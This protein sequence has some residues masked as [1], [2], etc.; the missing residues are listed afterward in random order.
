MKRTLLEKLADPVQR[1]P[2]SLEGATEGAPAVDAGVLRG[3]DGAAYPITA[4]IPRFVLTSDAGQA[5]T[6]KA[7]GFKWKK[8]DTYDSPAA[9]AVAA[10]WYLEK[11]DFASLDEW[12]A[13]FDRRESVIDIGSGSGFSSSLFLESPRWTGHAAWIGVDISEAIDVAKERLSSI[14]NTHFVQG[15]ALQLPFRDGG[16][17]TV[18]SE[19][20]MHHT[21]STHDALLSAARVLATGGEACFYVYKKKAP[22]REYTDD[23]VRAQ[24]APLSDD[25]AWDAMRSLTELGRALSATRATVDLKVDVPLLGIK[26]GAQDV[27]RLIYWNV[28]K[29]YWNDAL[30]FEEN[31]HI[32]FDWYRPRYAHRQTEAEVRQWCEE[33]RL[34]IRRLHDS[35][36]GYT[37]R[38]VKR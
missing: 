4:G 15:D 14:P 28:A 9:K 30:T 18:F 10:K 38:A 27:Q 5:Q 33:A 31:V 35:E 37:V 22:L 23:Y 25:E 1:K 3:A 19:G 12:A 17:D 29:L 36:A 34:D 7:F 32:N 6:S 24:I 21:P 2:L 8:R 11:Y 26:A 16:F 20:V 13:Y